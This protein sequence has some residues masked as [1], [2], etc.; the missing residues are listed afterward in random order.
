MRTEKNPGGVAMVSIRRTAWFFV[1]AV[2]MAGWMGVLGSFRGAA[3]ASMI[4]SHGGAGDLRA[5]EIAK[6]QTF[7]EQK[8]VLQKLV[9]YGV[10]PEEAM[11]KIRTMSDSDLHRLATLT[12]R[13]AAGADGGVGWLIG[14]A[15][16]VILVLVILMLMNKR[17]VVR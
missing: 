16:L 10:S 7:L 6:V 4:A 15:V 17:V 3:E 2:V 5:G 13:V 9:D 11:A 1:L 8:V 12:D 14:V